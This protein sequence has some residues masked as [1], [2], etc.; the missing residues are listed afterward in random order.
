[1]DIRSTHGAEPART[2]ESFTSTEGVDLELIV[3]RYGV[4]VYCHSRFF[5]VC[6]LARNGDSVLKY[7][8]SK[9]EICTR[10]HADSADSTRGAFGGKPNV[11]R[12]R[13]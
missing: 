1:V 6:A 7:K 4:G 8:F 9:S 13:K 10:S 2:R 11:K 3:D 5:Q 12:I